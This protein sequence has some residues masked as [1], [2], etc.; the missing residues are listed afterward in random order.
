MLILVLHKYVLSCFLVSKLGGSKAN[1]SGSLVFIID[2]DNTP[3]RKRLRGP[4][5]STVLNKLQESSDGNLNFLVN[6]SNLVEVGSGREEQEAGR[7]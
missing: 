3:K 5:A 7:V 1:A 6:P 4:R 2:T